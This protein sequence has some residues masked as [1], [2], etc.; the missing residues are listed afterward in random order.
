MQVILLEDVK[1]VGKKHDSVEVKNGYGNF[2]VASGKAVLASNKAQAIVNKQ[3]ADALAKYN[4]DVSK[5][6]Q[7]KNQIEKLK[8][9]FSLRTNNGQAFGS[10]SNKQV[11]EELAKNNL[12][13]DKFMLTENKN[14]G[15]GFHQIGIKLHKDVIAKLTIQVEGE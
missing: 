14:Y 4:L 5:A 12:K 7:I 15:L 3:K 8:L 10:I 1:N 2:L 9:I 11:L 13:I 6:N